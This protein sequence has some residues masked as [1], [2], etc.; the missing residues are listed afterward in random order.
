MKQKSSCL[1]DIDRM[2][3]FLGTKPL[4]LFGS[5]W[6]TRLGWF[7]TCATKSDGEF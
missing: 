6:S 5:G 7:E 3:V 2:Q 1:M 4:S